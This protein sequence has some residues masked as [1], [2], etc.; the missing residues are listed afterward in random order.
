MTNGN[1]VNGLATIAAQAVLNGA[2][3]YLRANKLTA[4]NGLLASKCREHA[5]LALRPALADAKEAI[6]AHMGQCAEATFLASM[7]L[8][9]IAAAKECASSVV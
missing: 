9:G 1:K 7:A 4:D 6:D 5:R 2:V 3:E 8:A